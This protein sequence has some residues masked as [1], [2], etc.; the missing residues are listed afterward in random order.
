[1]LPR[2]ELDAN[3]SLGRITPQD[4]TVAISSSWTLTQA[5][6]TK[7]NLICLSLKPKIKVEIL[8]RKTRANRG[9][10]QLEKLKNDLC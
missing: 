2:V 1:M 5:R 4:K 7:N 3:G 6:R 9:G 8:C 10:R